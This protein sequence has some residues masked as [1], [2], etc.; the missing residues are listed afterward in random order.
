MSFHDSNVEGRIFYSFHIFPFYRSQI[1]NHCRCDTV[2][3]LANILGQGGRS[4]RTSFTIVRVVRASNVKTTFRSRPI[5]AGFIFRAIRRFRLV[6]L[7]GR[8]LVSSTHTPTYT[9]IYICRNSSWHSI[10]RGECVCTHSRVCLR[11]R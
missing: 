7:P 1:A 8:E 6:I 3:I 9:Y 2:I 5:H 4:R 10:Y 11:L